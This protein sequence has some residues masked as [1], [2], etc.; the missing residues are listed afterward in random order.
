MEENYWNIFGK[1][2]PI[3]CKFEKN[4]IRI[5]WGLEIENLKDMFK[6][7]VQSASEAVGGLLNKIR[8]TFK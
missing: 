4:A 3:H 1:N 7:S 5:D 2:I 6:E 8:N